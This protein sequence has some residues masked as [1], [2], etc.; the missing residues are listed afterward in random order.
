MNLNGLEV[1]RELSFASDHLPLVDIRELILTECTKDWKHLKEQEDRLRRLA[2]GG[3]DEDAI[4]IGYIGIKFPNAALNFWQTDRGYE[5]TG[6]VPSDER[7]ASASDFYDLM[8]D[9]SQTVLAPIAVDYHLETKLG[10]DLRKLQEWPSNMS[11]N[12]L[13]AFV[14]SMQIRE[15]RIV[16][17]D[18]AAWH[19]FIIESYKSPG[20][21]NVDQVMQWFIDFSACSPAQANELGRSHESALSLLSAFSV[22]E[23]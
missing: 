19:N 8:N 22:S 9:F 5:I 13:R 12:A 18:N 23:L 14:S 17:T 3:L 21:L 4:V 10:E 1:A 6:I 15:Q 2:A 20:R 7:T 11:E 16:S